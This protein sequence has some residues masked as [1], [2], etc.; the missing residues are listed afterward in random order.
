MDRGD[1]SRNAVWNAAGA[2]QI[3][4]KEL[5]PAP[6]KRLVLDH[7]G[8]AE[9]SAKRFTSHANRLRFREDEVLAFLGSDRLCFMTGGLDDA[10][11]AP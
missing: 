6:H 4:A 1:A 2:I 11:T 3:A 8:V 7:V 10:R 9:H 5:A